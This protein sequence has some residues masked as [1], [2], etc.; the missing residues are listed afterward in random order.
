MSKDK[1]KGGRP[2]VITKE[3]GQII[4]ELMAQGYSLRQISKKLNH[5]HGIKCDR[6]TMLRMAVSMDPEDKW[7]CD[8]YAQSMN[9]RAHGLADDIIDICDDGSND[10]YEAESASGDSLI[11]KPDNEHINRAR[12]RVDT[13]KWILSKLLRKDYGDKQEIEHSGEVKFVP[14]LEIVTPKSK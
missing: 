8:Q 5:D 4:F 13:R 1:S 12:L 14:A 6:A 9:I 2:K 7:F 11:M 3:V 10:W